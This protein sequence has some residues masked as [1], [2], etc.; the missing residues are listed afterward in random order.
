MISKAFRISLIVFAILLTLALLSAVAYKLV[1]HRSPTRAIAE[2]LPKTLP[3]AGLFS[4]W[5]E[6]RNKRLTWHWYEPREH[7]DEMHDRLVWGYADRHSVAPGETFNLN[8]STDDIDRVADGHVEI[9]RIGYYGKTDRRLYWRSDSIHVIRRSFASSASSI[10]ANWPAGIKKVPTKSWSSGYYTVDF[11]SDSGHR[12][13]D[14]A[15]IVVRPPRQSTGDILVKLSTNTY[16]AYNAWGGH[17][18][19]Q[20]DFTFNYGAM[21]SFD[22]PTRSQFFRW[23]Y[24]YVMWLEKFAAQHGLTVGYASD[25]DTHSDKTLFEKYRLVIA[26]GHDE[27][28]SRREFDHFYERIFRLGKNTLFLGANMAF[29]QV[30]Y[31]DIHRP[32]VHPF[33]GRQMLSFKQEDDPIVRDGV[34]GKLDMAQEF[35][36]YARRPETML[37]GVGYQSFFRHGPEFRIAYHVSDAVN[38]PVFRDLFRGTGYHVGDDAADVVGYEWDNRDPKG[39]GRRLW[40]KSSSIPP[41]PEKDVHVLFNGHP[42]NYQGKQGLAEAVYFKSPAGARVFS[43]GTV[44]WAWGLTKKGFERKEFRRLNGNLLLWFLG[45]GGNHKL[46]SLRP[47]QGNQ[48]AERQNHIR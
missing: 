5:E 45:Q 34:H 10:G 42:V 32:G 20:D 27:Y 36:A 38:D 40:N 22:R 46:E 33:M 39:D 26:L 44:R 13:H 3:G 2:M 29:R 16:Q 47:G 48:V 14:L 9:Y 43:A 28:W 31:S 25:F 35:R 1:W 18:N 7:G 30:R 11:V 19:Y 15:Y 8:L 21:V 41:V 6:Y 4:G 23:E 17:S 12:D 24:Y 37:M